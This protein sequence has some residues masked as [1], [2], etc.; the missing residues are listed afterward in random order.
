MMD[1]NADCLKI[2]SPQWVLFL[3]HQRWAHG[4][5]LIMPVWPHPLSTPVSVWLDFC[6]HTVHGNTVWLHYPCSPKYLILSETFWYWCWI[7]NYPHLSVCDLSVLFHEELHSQ[8]DL[9]GIV[10]WSPRLNISVNSV[11]VYFPLHSL[12]VGHLFLWAPVSFILDFSVQMCLT[13]DQQLDVFILCQ[14]SAGPSSNNS[15]C[16]LSAVLEFD[17]CLN[18]PCVVG[19]VSPTF[20][21]VPQA[22]AENFL[23]DRQRIG[24]N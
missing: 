12:L 3:V 15:C 4:C 8:G 23:W 19:M 24:S 17:A 21:S 22:H 9:W 16:S 13:G 6:P 2:V 18:S 20:S 10:P 7:L 5:L 11:E 1:I 14:V